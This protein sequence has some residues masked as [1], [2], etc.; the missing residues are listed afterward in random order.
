MHKSG[1]KTTLAHNNLLEN[2]D[3][4]KSK[5]GILYFLCKINWQFIQDLEA[6]LHSPISF[7]PLNCQCTAAVKIPIN[8]VPSFIQNVVKTKDK[9]QFSQISIINFILQFV[10]ISILFCF[11]FNQQLPVELFVESRQRVCDRIKFLNTVRHRVLLLSICLLFA[12]HCFGPLLKVRKA[13]L[14]TVSCQCV[15]S[16]GSVPLGTWLEQTLCSSPD[17]DGAVLTV[18]LREGRRDQSTS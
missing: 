2:A 9:A 16:S 5:L 12:L 17:F 18:Q 13:A 10:C 6:A 3:P 14:A 11:A 8:F 4:Q 15:T 1:F 7:Q